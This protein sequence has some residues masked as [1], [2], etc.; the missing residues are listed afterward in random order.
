MRAHLA[1]FGDTRKFRRA[2]MLW[3]VA[4]TVFFAIYLGYSIADLVFDALEVEFAAD[5][6]IYAA[7]VG[8][9]FTAAVL[10]VLAFSHDSLIRRRGLLLIVVAIAG[11]FLCFSLSGLLWAGVGIAYASICFIDDIGA[12]LGLTRLILLI[13]ARRLIRDSHPTN[14]TRGIVDLSIGAWTIGYA[15][16]VYE[17]VLPHWGLYEEVVPYEAA[18]FVT[19]SLVW[20]IPPIALWLAWRSLRTQVAHLCAHCGYDVSHAPSAQ[21]PEC[22]A[23]L[24]GA[25][26][27]PA[28]ATPTAVRGA[29]S[30]GAPPDRR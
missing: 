6:A 1:Q 3:F 10:S 29:G 15:W 22:G 5:F 11:P 26:D 7:M 25:S 8:F 9:E 4:A 17:S 24:T 13:L 27:T 14:L 18:W 20:G 30:A 21:C 16:W 2:L 23:A 28:V 12:F 19:G